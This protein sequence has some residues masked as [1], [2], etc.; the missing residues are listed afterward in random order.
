MNAD[1]RMLTDKKT[2]SAVICPIRVICDQFSWNTMRAWT[3]IS[4]STYL[5]PT[6]WRVP[7]PPAEDVK[8][9][10]WQTWENERPGRAGKI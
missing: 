8:R 5:F 7:Q 6:L 2:Q 9:G 10:L 1:R 3:T 4:E